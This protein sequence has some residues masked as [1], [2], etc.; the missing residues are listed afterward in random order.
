MSGLDRAWPKL[1]S[2][3]PYVWA[4]I[5]H[6]SGHL[7][8]CEG[9][10]AP[11]GA[12]CEIRLDDGSPGILA[13]VIAFSSAVSKLI[14]FSEVAGLSRSSRIRVLSRR[15]GLQVGNHLLGRVIDSLGRPVDGQPLHCSN[16]T[17]QYSGRL[18]APL[19]RNP[20]SKSLD[21]GVRAINGTLTLAKGQRVALIAGS[22]VGKSTLLGMMTR[23]TRA[24]VV[25]VALIGE[26][27]R[28]AGEFIS[29]ILGPKGL[30]K[31]VVVLATSDATSVMRRRAADT[32]HLI[33]E[34]F[35]DQGKDVL[36]LCD[37]LTR[38]AHAQ[39]EIGLAA[40]EPPTSKGYPPS[41]FGDLPKMM[42]RGGCSDADGTITSVYTVLA[43]FDEGADPIV[44]MA[45]STL[46][47]QIM[48]SRDLADSGLYPAINL[49][50]SISRLA[51]KVCEPS[52]VSLA[53]GFR[54]LWSLYE[55]NKDLILVGAYERG[56]DEELDKAIR[57]RPLMQDF[58]R[59]Q[60]HENCSLDE[61]HV[62]LSKIMAMGTQ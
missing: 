33:A 42:E 60:E 16:L 3:T 14:A 58:I 18:I 20:I 19:D 40:R 52:L 38:V 51:A 30:E 12:L 45:R 1:S 27:G 46:D 4:E 10:E 48:L 13:E 15:L 8:E 28:E 26:R 37:S 11:V 61:A 9:L 43:E 50:G 53:T 54:R 59:Q 21:V 17:P 39:R 44:E 56:S 31:S 6:A 36:L 29:E 23:Q 57:L 34:Y 25:V 41:V 7:I 5:K 2:P 24:D 35:R 49:Q 62:A 47:G 55:A 22:G 32:A